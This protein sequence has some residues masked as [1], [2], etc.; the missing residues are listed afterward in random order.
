LDGYESQDEN[1]YEFENK[2]EINEKASGKGKCSQTLESRGA[3]DDITG[4]G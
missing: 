2:E 3:E 1:Q 4:R